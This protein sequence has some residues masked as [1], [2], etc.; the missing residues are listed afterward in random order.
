M[1]RAVTHQWVT[2][3]ARNWKV[4][5]VLRV[6][7]LVKIKYAYRLLTEKGVIIS[8]CVKAIIR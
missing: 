3:S 8:K 7:A 6:F 4:W 5:F 1:K 2:D